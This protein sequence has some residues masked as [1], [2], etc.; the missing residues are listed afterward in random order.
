MQNEKGEDTFQDLKNFI[1]G[2]GFDLNYIFEKI[3]PYGFRLKAKLAVRA[4]GD[5]VHIG[6]FKE[7]THEII[8]KQGCVLHHLNIN[9]AIAKIKTLIKH[10]KIA[11]Y[12]EKTH[13]GV[14]RYL[15]FL[16]N[17]K[18]ELQ[19][20]FVVTK[21][22][23]GIKNLAHDLFVGHVATS[24]WINVQNQMTNTIFSENFEHLYGEKMLGYEV[25]DKTIY[26]HPGSFCQANLLEFT[27]LIK[28]ID[29]YLT[30]ETKALDL[31]SGT[32]VFGLCLEKHFETIVFAETN[33]FSKQGF[34]ASSTFIDKTK[35]QFVIC[36]AK[37]VLKD[38]LD[39]DVVF[40]DPPRKGLEKTIKPLLGSLKKGAKVFYISC[41]A[42]SL[43]RDLK[44]LLE[45]NF[46]LKF[47]RSYQFFPGSKEIE[48]LCI[49]EKSS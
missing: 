33:P 1:E 49:L 32:G 3:N 23:E 2:L 43:K 26:F 11:P 8:D 31:Y 30:Q 38:H 16:V 28:V 47:I 13:Q 6:L 34:E 37:E 39:A 19:I 24:L 15:Q 46:D 40:I 5:E 35:K 48:T 36:D 7:G 4:L 12:D 41:G 45:L 10:L 27:R 22:D 25:F 20:V 21:V 29:D 9:K 42:L 17:Q 18:G 44:E 14:I